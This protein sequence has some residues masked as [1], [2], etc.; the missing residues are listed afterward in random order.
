MISLKNIATIARYE[1]KVLWRNWFFR[2]FALAIITILVFF[3]IG[4]FSPVGNNR[5]FHRAI[6]SGIPYANMVFL[7]LVQVAVL[8][9]LASGIIKNNK[10]LDTN[11]VFYVRPLS[12]ADLVLGKALALLILFF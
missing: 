9:F 4:V 10:K 6:S 7:N 12:N 11:E 3:N 5:W 2:I 1:S 8:I